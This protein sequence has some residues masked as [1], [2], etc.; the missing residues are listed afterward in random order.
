VS[1][2]VCNKTT[3]HG[4]REIRDFWADLAAAERRAAD[5]GAKAFGEFDAR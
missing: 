3:Q 1:K 4:G 5:W 2:G